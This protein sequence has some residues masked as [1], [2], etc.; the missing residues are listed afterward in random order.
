MI[1]LHLKILSESLV[2]MIVWLTVV[3][4]FNFEKWNWKYINCDLPFNPI[5][6]P[7]IVFLHFSFTFTCILFIHAQNAVLPFTIQTNL[8][9]S[10]MLTI[11]Y[12]FHHKRYYLT[13]NND[14]HVNNND[15]NFLAL[16]TSLLM[17]NHSNPYLTIY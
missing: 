6:N 16:F 5:F 4:C 10:T 15:N 9:L 17:D 7:K 2:S 14:K 3:Q 11:F 1:A 12:F 8:N 13:N